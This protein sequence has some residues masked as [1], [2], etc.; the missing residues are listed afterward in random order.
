MSCKIQNRPISFSI[1]LLLLLQS[2]LQTYGQ[3][4]FRTVVLT[5]ETA[6]IPF[7]TIDFE[8]IRDPVI[9]DVGN[10]VFRADLDVFPG[11]GGSRGLFILGTDNEELLAREQEL[12]PELGPNIRF[13]D[14]NNPVS[15]VDQTVFFAELSGSGI[16]SSN[17]IALLSRREDVS[18]VIARLGMEVPN[19][20]PGTVIS[21][22]LFMDNPVL[23]RSGE[24][25]FSASLSG[26]NVTTDND[27]AIFVTVDSD[28]TL[29]VRE[30]DIASTTNGQF[31]IKNVHGSPVFND[32]G[33]FAFVSELAD[34]G[35][36]NVSSGKAPILSSGVFV[37]TDGVV[38]SVAAE[39]DHISGLPEDVVI[40]TTFSPAFGDSLSLNNAG[41][42]VFS[43][44]LEGPTVNLENN[45]VVVAT[46]EE[47][48][49]ELVARS[50]DTVPGDA[51]RFVFRGGFGSPVIN[52]AGQIA[53]RARIGPPDLPNES[54]ECIVRKVDGRL[55]VLT[56]AGGQAP[57]VADGIQFGTSFNNN[58]FGDPVLNSSGKTAFFAMLQGPGVNNLNNSGIWMTGDDGN[59]KLVAR[60]GDVFDVDDNP[61]Q[62]DLRIIEFVGKFRSAGG[63]DG[64][65]T[66]LNNQGQLVFCL[67]F[68]DGKQGAFVAKPN[69]SEIEYE[70]LLLSGDPSPVP[71]DTI[72][73][74]DFET[75]VLNDNGSVAFLAEFDGPDVSPQ[76]DR[77]IFLTNGNSSEVVVQAGNQVPGLEDGIVFDRD[78][79]I[80][81]INNDNQVA[82]EAHAFGNGLDS[83]QD[84]LLFLSDQGQLDLIVREGD[85]APGTQDGTVLGGGFPANSPF[86]EITID[87]VGQA[88]FS[89]TV[90]GNSSDSAIYTQLENDLQ[91]VVK[92]GA[93]APGF[94]EDITL[95]EVTLDGKSES[96]RLL[97][98]ANLDGNDINSDNN[99]VLYSFENQSFDLI[100]REGEPAI[101]F[102]LGIE[103]L[104]IVGADIN[105][106]GQIVF[107]SFLQGPGIGSFNENDEA[108][109]T[110][111]NGKLE[112]LLQ[113]GITLPGTPDGVIIASLSFPIINVNGDI[114]FQSRMEVNSN[115]FLGSGIF[116]DRDGKVE[117]V[118]RSQT[119]APGTP[120]GVTFTNFGIG[121]PALS[122]TGQVAFL[123]E[124]SG[125]GIDSSNNKGIW[126]TDLE[127]N[128]Q[129]VVRRGDQ[130][131]VS[132]DPEVSDLRTVSDLE[133]IENPNGQNGTANNFNDA[134]E[135]LFL[136]RFQGGSQ[137][138][139]I[140]ELGPEKQILIGDVNF[141]GVVDL[142]DVNPFVELLVNQ[143]FQLEAD[144]NRN[145]VVDLLDIAPLIQI[146]SS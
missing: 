56:Q 144:I 42:V 6:P 143:K 117:F 83:S 95:N 3:I 2:G 118:A 139:V 87:G 9:N 140:A 35:E 131:D 23:N 109:F 76:F 146:L 122:N 52:G 73:Y 99:R 102:D 55:S 119:Q 133:M 105:E 126:A 137:G 69:G 29:A 15:V 94:D 132:K 113:S 79:E 134:G 121:L 101:G 70:T 1:I 62:Q 63:E 30:G 106:S 145:G 38:Q 120:D 114:V 4:E 116:L 40:G 27:E 68:T 24:A 78:F 100:A 58:D 84:D 22:F 14:F 41:Q 93:T 31:S 59:L 124:V 13:F 34:S 88:T 66:V 103:Y 50:G 81:I 25:V 33:E 136:A 127:G 112:L 48:T 47:G 91:L 85:P 17:N 44:F 128:L 28:L 12:V 111:R 123:G 57:G 115:D 125:A 86:N 20:S 53:F 89:T 5:G 107:R 43:A 82:F 74:E 60:S 67:V 65:G 46:D 75:P 138:I 142:L 135:L 141:D 129:L 16:N 21:E 110:D 72:T 54:I 104:G 7:P 98:S 97:F 37:V 11:G 10:I 45:Q 26:E 64:R 130:I 19:L 18:T 32:F 51:K 77:A 8:L 92:E 80:P 49:L 96:G 90:T 36:S 108:L 39:G 61:V 71:V